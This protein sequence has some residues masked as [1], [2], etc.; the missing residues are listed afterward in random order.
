MAELPGLAGDLLGVALRPDRSHRVAPPRL[1]GEELDR[2]SSPS[3]RRAA[4]VPFA[5]EDRLVERERVSPA[6]ARRRRRS[7]RPPSRRAARSPGDELLD[8][9][10]PDD[11]VP[12]HRGRPVR[13]EPRAGR[14]RASLDTSCQMPIAALEDEDVEKERVAPVAENEGQR[15]QRRE[16]PVEDV[17]KTLARTML[18]I[19]RLVVAGSTGPRS[20]ISRAASASERPWSDRLAGGGTRVSVTSA[21]LARPEA[22]HAAE[23]PARPAATRLERRDSAAVTAAQPRAA[24]PKGQAASWRPEPR[25]S[26]ASRVAACGPLTR[27]PREPRPSA[28]A[29]PLPGC[30]PHGPRCVTP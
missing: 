5:R 12:R 21:T 25:P 8:L 1:D 27:P 7:D 16:D 19:D 30:G 6:R 29:A 10:V 3:A 26:A 2:T 28:S 17:G 18:A 20:S 15:P 24:A 13:P 22:A 9:H 11:P 4:D 23:R 14:A